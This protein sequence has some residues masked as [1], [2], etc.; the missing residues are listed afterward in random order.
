M[1]CNLC[2]SI[3]IEALPAFPST[4]INTES[5]WSYIHAFVEN[6][7]EEHPGPPGSPHQPDL[8]SLKTSAATCELCCLILNQ[9][10]RF[11][12]EFRAAEQDEFFRNTYNKGYPGFDLWVTRRRAGGEGFWV[13]STGKEKDRDRRSLFLLAA[14]GLC[15]TDGTS[16]LIWVVF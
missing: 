12:D 4:Y 1:L 15:V 5:K 7:A 16:L 8:E 14:F 6:T 2:V 13:L 9:I 3:P 10:D 11:I